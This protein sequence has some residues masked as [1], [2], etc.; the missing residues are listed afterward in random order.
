MLP[1]SLSSMELEAA[2]RLVQDLS[3]DS[4]DAQLSSDRMG[5]T[6]TITEAQLSPVRLE[7]LVLLVA[8]RGLEIAYTKGAG[9]TIVPPQ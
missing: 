2:C 4:I 3:A 8:E 1:G 5:A 9:L 7:K 6:V